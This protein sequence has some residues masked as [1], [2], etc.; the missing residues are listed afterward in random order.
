MVATKGG[1]DAAADAV[2]VLGAAVLAPGVASDALRRRI[3]HGLAVYFARHARY[4]V[5][6]GGI[7]AAPPAEAT[8][9]REIALAAGVPNE[10]IIVEDQSRNTFENAVYVGR[11]LRRDGLRRAVL[12]T[13]AFHLPRALYCFR[14]LGLAVEGDGVARQP[15]TSRLKWWRQYL[16]E[17]VRFARCAALFL[18]GSHK[19]IVQRV[20]GA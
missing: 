20:W 2:I 9:M 14:R 8:L 6:S 10:R 19:S 7:V 18:I 11:I 1:T 17:L 12:V 13:D 4:L 16:E 15:S 3:D 5:V